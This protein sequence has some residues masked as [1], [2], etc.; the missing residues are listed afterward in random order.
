MTPLSTGA[1]GTGY[2]DD[3]SQ[4]YLERPMDDGWDTAAITVTRIVIRH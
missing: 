2:G 4:Y 1:L 3:I